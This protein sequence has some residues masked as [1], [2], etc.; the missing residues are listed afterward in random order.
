MKTSQYLILL[1][2]GTVLGF[3]AWLAVLALIDPGLGWPAL[4]MF[5]LTAGLWLFGLTAAISTLWRLRRHG[6]EQAHVVV[7]MSMRQASVVTGIFLAGLIFLYFGQLSLPVLVLLGLAAG[8]LE[9]I[10]AKRAL[11]QAARRG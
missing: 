9:W 5:L 10:F 7:P 11:A 4:G 1:L 8:L 3:G 6:E 2:V